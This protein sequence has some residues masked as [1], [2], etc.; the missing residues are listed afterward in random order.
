MKVSRQFAGL[1]VV[2]AAL[3]GC[4]NNYGDGPVLRFLGAVPG[5]V[6]PSDAIVEQAVV[7]STADSEIIDALRMRPSVLMPGTPYA[8]VAEAVIASNARVAEAELHVAALRA[9]AAR[10]NWLPRLGP[11]VSLNSLGDFVADLVVQQVLFDNGRKVAE[12]D[13]AKA[14]VE[15]A[16]V[17]LVED[18]ND[19]VYNALCLYLTVQQNR[20]LRGHLDR[21]L[22][23][24]AKFEWVMQQRVNGGVSDMSDL[25]VL[26]QKSATLRARSGEAASAAITA[27][28]ELNAM[29]AQPLDG[30]SGLGGLRAADA[31]R[32]LPVLRAEA[33]REKVMAEARIARASHLPGLAGS[34]A[35]D[36]SARLEVTT[37]SPF[38]LGSRADMKAIEATKE[39]AERRVTQADEDVRRRIASRTRQLEAYRYQAE[40][41]RGLTVNAKRNLELFQAQFEGGQRQ[42]MDVVGTYETFARAL[43]TEIDL[44]YKAARAELDLAR[45]KGALAEG[46]RI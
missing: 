15:L 37:D 34:A 27:M 22:E 5:V 24:M 42:A 46:A 18:G 40:Q 1:C 4:M 2:M 43:E 36:G 35:S 25:N 45:L 39:T 17:A 3:P 26:Q 13:L 11:R 23:D 6:E 28:A 20:D 31:G 41:V 10:R 21:A 38:G 8:T 12:R 9:E 44:K 30:L 7:R 19:R 14:N 16:A 29:A 33:E 32:A